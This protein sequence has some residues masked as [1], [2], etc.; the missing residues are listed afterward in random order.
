MKKLSQG[1]F[2]QIDS[3]WIYAIGAFHLSI[4]PNKN[5]EFSLHVYG[6]IEPIPP[7]TQYPTQPEW[8]KALDLAN[9]FME[10]Y[11]VAVERDTP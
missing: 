2:I 7:A 8:T 1:D 5:G 10:A 6:A 3:Q 11:L 4:I 9:K